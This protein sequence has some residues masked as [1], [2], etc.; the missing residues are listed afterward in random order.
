MNDELKARIEALAADV[1][2]AVSTGE[3][4]GMG[5]LVTAVDAYRAAGGT[6]GA[7]GMGAGVLGAIAGA[8]LFS[9][10]GPGLFRSNEVDPLDQPIVPPDSGLPG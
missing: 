5:A 4:S 9:G 7:P 8:A 3:T 6:F 1:A 10:S 2:A